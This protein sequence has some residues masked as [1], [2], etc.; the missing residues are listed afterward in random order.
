MPNSRLLTLDGSGHTSLF[1]S[2]CIDG[3][4]DTYLLTGEVPPAGTVCPV[5]EV[6]FSQAPRQRRS[7]GVTAMPFLLPPM[8]MRSL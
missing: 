1:L 2:G 7:A 6:P 5:D 8:V 4:V 3:Y